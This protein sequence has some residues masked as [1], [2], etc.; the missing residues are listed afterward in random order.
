MPAPAG[1]APLLSVAAVPPGPCPAFPLVAPRGPPA[2]EGAARGG[3]Q[4]IALPPSRY[5]AARG[6]LTAAPSLPALRFSLCVVSPAYVGR[7]EGGGVAESRDGT[8]VLP[9]R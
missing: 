2:E 5:A 3:F 6:R 8:L 1:S 9:G 4:S 7:G